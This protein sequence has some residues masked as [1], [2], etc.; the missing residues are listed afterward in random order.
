MTEKQR[1]ELRKII[2][3]EIEGLGSTIAQAEANVVPVAPDSAIGRISRMDTIINQEISRSSLST[4]KQRRVRLEH[5]L[6]R[7]C[8]PGFG[9]C[10]ECGGIIPMARLLAVPESDLCVHC[11]E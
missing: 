11:A 9:E 6:R 2:L 10:A 1:S 8:E 5:A 4:L 7:L 3:D